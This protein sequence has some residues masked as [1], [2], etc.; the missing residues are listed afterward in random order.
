MPFQK[1]NKIN[2]GRKFS[3]EH[4]QKL[5]IAKKGRKLS[6]EQR[7]KMIKYGKDNAMYGMK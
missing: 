5:G 6:Q 1:G 7:M 2:L 3:L 4:K